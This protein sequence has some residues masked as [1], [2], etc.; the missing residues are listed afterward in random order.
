VGNG[1]QH[2]GSSGGLVV[3]LDWPSY[4][5]IESGLDSASGLYSFPPTATSGSIRGNV[6]GSTAAFGSLLAMIAGLQA[7][8]PGSR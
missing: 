4:D 7:S 6:N 2:Y 3:A 1:L 8:L 5:E